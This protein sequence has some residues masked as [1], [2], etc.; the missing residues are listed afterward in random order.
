MKDTFVDTAQAL[1]KY[2]FLIAS[3]QHSED[4]GITPFCR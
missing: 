1:D 2:A 4:R 3:K